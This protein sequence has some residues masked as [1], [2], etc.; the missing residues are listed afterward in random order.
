MLL[1]GAVKL[2]RKTFVVALEFAWHI[3]FYSSYI[4]AISKSFVI[5]FGNFIKNVTVLKCFL[6]TENIAKN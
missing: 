6:T 4:F 3:F 5:S 1:K 2:R